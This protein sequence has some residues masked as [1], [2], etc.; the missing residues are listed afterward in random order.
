MTAL[1]IC[2]IVLC[3]IMFLLN[4]AGVIAA[5]SDDAAMCLVQLPALGMAIIVMSIVLGVYV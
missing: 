2:A 1:L 4:L 3:G 5:G